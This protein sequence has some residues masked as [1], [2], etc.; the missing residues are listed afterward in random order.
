MEGAKTGGPHFKEM[1]IRMKSE[2]RTEKISLEIEKPDETLKSL[3]FDAIHSQLI[4]VLFVSKDVSMSLGAK[5]LCEAVR[6]FQ[7]YDLSGI[8]VIFTWGDQGAAGIDTMGTQV[9]VKATKVDN[10]VDTCGAGDTFTAGVISSLIRKP[11]DLLTALERGCH[12]AAMKI[13]QKS[14][15]GLHLFFS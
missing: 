14:L 15:K 9:L 2:H 7:R 1:L 12:L 11:T 8:T 5:N 3:M 4:D 10:V 6:V 13:Q